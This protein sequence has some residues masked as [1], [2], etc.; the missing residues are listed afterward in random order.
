MSQVSD[1]YVTREFDQAFGFLKTKAKKVSA[2]D[3]AIDEN[4]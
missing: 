3:D 1:S 4:I 2:D